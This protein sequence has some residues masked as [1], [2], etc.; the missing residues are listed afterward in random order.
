[1]EGEFG[2]FDEGQDISLEAARFIEML[3]KNEV[4]YF[5]PGII[6]GVIEF[7]LEESNID[8]AEK[9][10][11]IALDQHPGSADVKIAEC[12]VL[13]AKGLL[14]EAYSQILILEESEPFN[15]DLLLF[16]SGV[17]SQMHKHDLAVE[18][19]QR[20]LEMEGTDSA[21]LLLDLAFEYE[22]M[23]NY[24]KA[25]DCLKRVLVADPGNETALFELSFCYELD[26]NLNE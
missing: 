10:L 9:A 18:C 24:E 8:V 13:A 22:H 12:Q 16:K 25:I 5:D 3:E 4:Y 7:F 17:L 11:I 14:N 6:S 20:V 21:D 23:E 19:L 1:M 15:E 26:S 2:S